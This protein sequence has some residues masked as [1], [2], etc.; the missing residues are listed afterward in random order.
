MFKGMVDFLKK[1]FF[2]FALISIVF[3]VSVVN[4]SSGT[5]LSGWDTL[6][7]EFDLDLALKRELAGVWR[8]EMGLG[9]LAG[10]SDVSELPRILLLKLFSLVLPLPMLRYSYV[11][12]SL[13]LGPLGVYFFLN[14]FLTENKHVSKAA[15]FLG[16]FYYLLNFA[17]LQHFYVPLEMFTTLYAALPW[18]FY[19]SLKHVEGKGKRSL[20]WIFL[21][22]LFSAP[23]AWASTLFYAYLLCLVAFLLMIV[24]LSKE[25]GLKVARSAVV[26]SL[27][28]AVN[29]F[30]LAPNIYSVF[31][32]GDIVINS[33]IN[34]LFSDEAF[35][36]N[37]AYGDIGNVLIN[38]NHLFSWQ[39]YDARNAEYKPL[40]DEWLIHLNKPL[41]NTALYSVVFFIFSGIVLVIIKKEKTGVSLLFP[42]MITLFFLINENPP[43]GFIYSFIRNNFSVF[44]EALRMPFTKFSIPFIFIMS[45]F[46][47]YLFGSFSNLS[48]RVLS[49]FPA[50]TT[51]LN[52][53]MEKKSF[54][55]V[56][57]KRVLAQGVSLLTVGLFILIML[58]KIYPML[59]VF[60]G[61]MIS[62][63]LKIDIPDEYFSLFELMRDKEGRIAKFPLHTRFGWTYYDWGFQGSSFTQFGLENPVLDRDYDRWSAEN[64]T[65]YNQASFALYSKDVE[66][67]EKVLAKFNVSYIL[68]DKSVITPDTGN[69]LFSE[70]ILQLF[71]A[72]EKIALE[73]K[74]GFLEL[75]RFDPANKEKIYA[76]DSYVSVD[77]DSRYSE[78][79]Y[80]YQR[81]GTYV[82]GEKEDVIYPFVNFDPRASIKPD[83][84]NGNLIFRK[85]IGG[86]YVDR[87]N[88]KSLILI[89]RN[90]LTDVYA[91]ITDNNFNIIFRYQ[92]PGI[93]LGE[94]QFPGSVYQLEKNFEVREL[95]GFISIGD[96]IFQI[97]LNIR[98]EKYLG[99]LMLPLDGKVALT[100][101]SSQSVD[102]SDDIEKILTKE[103]RLCS[104]P[105]VSEG[106]T[107]KH[108]KDL[109]MYVADKSVCLGTDLEAAVDLLAYMHFETSSDANIFPEI[110]FSGQDYRHCLSNGLPKVYIGERN[111]NKSFDYYA[112]LK[113]GYYWIDYVGQGSNFYQGYV[114]YLNISLASYP[115]LAE[116]EVS[117]TDIAVASDDIWFEVG[118]V[119]SFIE[120]ASPARDLF[121]EN[122]ATGRG[123]PIA[124]NCDSLE[125]G[126]VEKYLDGESSLYKAY[127]GGSSCDYF[128]YPGLRY[129]Q[130][131][132]LNITNENISGRNLKLYLY[133]SQSQRADAEV[134][135]PKNKSSDLI[136]LLSKDLTGSGYVI[137]L[138]SRSFEKIESV[139]R[140]REISFMPFPER[141][142]SHIA[143]NHSDA[144]SVLKQN[145]L[146]IDNIQ[147][148]DGSSYLIRIY[149]PEGG[150]GLFVLDEAFADGWLAYA[151]CKGNIF[152]WE[153]N[154]PWY[155][156]EKLKHLKVNGW[157]NGWSVKGGENC[158][159]SGTDGVLV[160]IVY[161]PQY[162]QYLGYVVILIT[163]FWIVKKQIIVK[164]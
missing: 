129:D 107:V 40:L 63:S 67:L 131:Y 104:D 68:F 120:V 96:V 33:K 14:L 160:H 60:S 19:F 28:I 147:K 31:K 55:G 151:V 15:S 100:I 145:Q 8:S 101:Y 85:D 16:S 74:I 13:I 7:P 82:S 71:E 42:L 24:I 158:M 89:E 141:W 150:E 103:P 44:E 10:H 52:V 116:D 43:T 53:L 3:F 108:D 114:D 125:R 18:I 130:S 139:N 32:G 143:V 12:L 109:M 2:L 26:F 155:F 73:E 21:I 41:I 137:N 123:Y 17:T 86:K 148:K 126:S 157:A 138:E 20:M 164:N 51:H 159:V 62:P 9:N 45:Y 106:R 149:P 39:E 35:M 154:L 4:Y 88:L 34:L 6:H 1:N 90:L 118:D 87:I 5:W 99:S 72:S 95:P 128:S 121:S 102:E 66:L 152:G 29:S 58:M 94:K 65:F 161:W 142:L 117:I 22:S 46:L 81:Y 36:S 153:F 110:C 146:E 97:D 37:Q 156:G 140:L 133:N 91:R 93:S 69:H 49:R 11:F 57:M 38:K 105:L 134:L 59:P 25:K 135:L 111:G 119:V 132:Y 162:L 76:P 75:Y 48:K 92:E 50:R 61:N 70:E 80:I 77:M 163:L 47:A 98:E 54:F 64:E 83:I 78:K 56:E 79:D 84:K 23:A 30:W 122:F 112:P 127:D 144:I 124:R 27:I 115:A 136:P 113:K